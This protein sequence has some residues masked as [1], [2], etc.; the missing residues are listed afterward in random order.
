LEGQGG[1]GDK[2]AREEKVLL[3]RRK[4]GGAILD[5]ILTTEGEEALFTR[6]PSA[7]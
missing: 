6:K 7:K 3:V 2:V 1:A 4:K 5:S